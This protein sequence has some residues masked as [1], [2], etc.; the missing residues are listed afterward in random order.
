MMI[1]FS[2]PYSK[3]NS[4]PFCIKLML[5]PSKKPES[6]DLKTCNSLIR[7]LY[8]MCNRILVKNEPKKWKNDCI[9]II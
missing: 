5:K 7:D 8:M 2:E 3:W 9:Q 1:N 6:D 4:E